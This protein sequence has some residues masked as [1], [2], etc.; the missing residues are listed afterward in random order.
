MNDMSTLLE[1]SVGEQPKKAAVVVGRMNPPTIGHYAV[2][3]AVKKYIRDHEDLKLEAI[4]IVVI[5]EGKETSKDKKKNP[6]SAE[7]RIKFMTASGKADGIKFIVASSAFAAFEEVR[8]AGFEPV[9]VAAGSDR[10]DSY[11]QMLDKYFLTKAGEKIK[12]HA[13]TLGRTMGHTAKKGHEKEALADILA[14]VDAEIPVEM[15]SASLARLAV[16]KNEQEKFAILTGLVDKPELAKK[17][18]DKIK[19]AMNGDGDG[20]A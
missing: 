2:F 4:P 13:I 14:H 11:L 9:A 17:M 15:V 18:F 8:K 20:A 7:D 19:T 12:H 3:D 6:L 1:E 10:A 16:Q 5:I